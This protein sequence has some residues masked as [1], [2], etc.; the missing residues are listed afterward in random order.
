MS[1][2]CPYLRY[3]AQRQSSFK[4]GIST[5]RMADILT[6]SDGTRKLEQGFNNCAGNDRTRVS[7]C[8]ARWGRR[9]RRTSP[10]VRASSAV[11]GMPKRPTPHGPWKRRVFAKMIRNPRSS[12]LRHFLFETT[13]IHVNKNTEY[14][15]D[16]M[17]ERSL[18]PSPSALS[19]QDLQVDQGH[20]K[21]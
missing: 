1:V 20:C 6:S 5:R 17:V 2:D 21:L 11:W 16:E 4:G 15:D 8:G 10:S 14:G 9:I 7:D 3:F 18:A 12:Q 19:C 13:A